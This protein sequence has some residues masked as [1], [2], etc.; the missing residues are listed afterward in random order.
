VTRRAAL[1]RLLAA[2]AAM[3]TCCRVGRGQESS[4]GPARGVAASGGKLVERLPSGC[5]IWQVTTERLNQSNIYCEAIYCSGDSRY[6]VYERT[7]AK[8]S[9]NP[10]E[11]MVVELGTWK[12]HLLDTG[13]SLEGCAM[14]REGVFYYVKRGPNKTLQ[15]RRADLAAGRPETVYCRKDEPWVESLGTV[16]PDGRSY[17]GMVRLD[18]QWKMFGIVVAD[19]GKHEES[20][21]DRDPFIFNAHPQFEPVRGHEM[22]IQH[23][24][25]GKYTTDGK[26]ECLVGPEGATLY[27]LSVPAGKRTEL[28]VGTPFTTPITGHEAWIGRTGEILLSVTPSGTFA[29]EKGNLLAVRSGSAARVVARGYRFNHVGVSLCGEFFCCDDWQGAGKLVVGSIKTG[30]TAVVCESRA[31]LAGPQNTHPHAYLTPDLRWVIFNSDRS[32]FPHIHAASIPE[33]L[34]K[35]LA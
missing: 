15:L 35:G 14:T 5:E 4:R 19:L 7:A 20:I 26:L 6:F 28:E 3:E 24:R 23:N 25:G 10:T 16:S 34:L 17:A 33:G 11:F 8:P 18:R 13:V 30:K 29:P 21:L 31:S 1:G 2:A 12:Q 27:L 9:A 32:G 22:L